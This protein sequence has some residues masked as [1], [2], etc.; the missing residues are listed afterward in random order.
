MIGASDLLSPSL[1]YDGT[2]ISSAVKFQLVVV[3]VMNQ[4]NH[5]YFFKLHLNIKH[6][7]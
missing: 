5:A 3:V 1:V 2:Q 7:T 6:P 4:V